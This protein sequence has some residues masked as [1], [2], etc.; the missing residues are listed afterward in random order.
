MFIVKEFYKNKSDHWEADEFLGATYYSSIIDA[1]EIMDSIM[2][3]Q[4][5]VYT[6]LFEIEFTDEG[7]I[8]ENQLTDEEIKRHVEEYNEY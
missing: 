6:C 2:I 3:D 1:L 5:Q 8:C 4:T 7:K